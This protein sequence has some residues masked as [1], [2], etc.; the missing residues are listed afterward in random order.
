MPKPSRNPSAKPLPFVEPDDAIARRVRQTCMALPGTT[1]TNSW[2]HPNFKANGRIFVTLEWMQRRPSIAL[3]LTST[4][5]TSLSRKPGYFLT[6]YGR[7][8]WIS[9]WADRR[10][11]WR[12]VSGLIRKSHDLTSQKRLAAPT[13]VATKRRKAK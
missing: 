3:R 4:D 7:G 6:P 12:T 9:V 11:D 10:L 13:K 2:G 8:Q 1:E 5:I